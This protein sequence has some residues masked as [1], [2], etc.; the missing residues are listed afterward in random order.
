MAA[1]SFCGVRGAA[2]GE[3]AV[4]VD[5]VGDGGLEEIGGD[6]LGPLAQLHGRGPGMGPPA[7]RRE[8]CPG[9]TVAFAWSLA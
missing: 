1:E 7:R 4:G 5:E 2:D 3:Q 8:A 6:V 9:R